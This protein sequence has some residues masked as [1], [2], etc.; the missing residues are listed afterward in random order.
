MAKVAARNASL[1]VDDSTGA[2][3]AVGGLLNNITL[4][5]SAEAPEVTGF[6]DVYRQRQQ[7]G[8]KDAELSFDAFY[9][10]GAAESDAILG[11]ILGASTRFQFGPA[12]SGAGA[13]KYAACAIL[14]KY[15]M[16]F[17]LADAG[18]VSGTLVLRNNSS[19]SLPGTWA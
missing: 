2:S 14:T 8:L 5:L 16:K 17:A 12:G 4:T 19:A 13:R 6:G 10:T 11:G 7:D 15:D 3:Q 18:Q 9:G 1:Y